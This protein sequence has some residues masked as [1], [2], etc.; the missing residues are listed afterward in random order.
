LKNIEDYFIFTFFL[1]NYFL[2]LGSCVKLT[3][4][5]IFWVCTL[6]LCENFYLA[7]SC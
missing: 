4:H 2:S 7:T 1:E 3:S 5:V 6:H